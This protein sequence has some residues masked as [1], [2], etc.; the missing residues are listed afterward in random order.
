M[1]VIFVCVVMFVALFFTT[2][3]K[4]ETPPP[5]WVL[6]P[7]AA[8]DPDRKWTDSAPAAR[9]SF[10]LALRLGTNDAAND[11]FGNQIAAVL[12]GGWKITR[13]EFVGVYV[14]GG[15]GRPGSLLT[16]RCTPGDECGERSTSFRTGAEG[17]HSFLPGERFNPWFGAALGFTTARAALSRPRPSLD[18]TAVAVGL[19]TRIMLGIDI[20]V[21]ETFGVGPYI[22]VTYTPG[23]SAKLHD[24]GTRDLKNTDTW[25]SIGVR[26][27]LFP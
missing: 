23:V 1:K 3:T 12:E 5:R 19:E 2:I 9:T 11:F 22:D 7:D 21:N 26:F 20:R 10:Q 4:A 13:S 25:S 27:V 24:N 16:Q 14:S 17:I 15:I 18:A 6:A 8:T